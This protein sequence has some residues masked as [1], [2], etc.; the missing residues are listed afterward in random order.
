MKVEIAVTCHFFQ[1]RMSWMISSLIQQQG[2][3]PEIV[4]NA[5]YAIDTGEPSTQETLNY[6]SKRTCGRPITFKHTPY[7]GTSELQYRGLVRNR[8]LAN[9]DADFMFFS[10][11]DML[12]GPYWFSKLLP[13]LKANKDETRMMYTGRYSTDIAKSNVLVDSYRYPAIIPGAFDMVS[14]L[15]KKKRRNCGAGFCQIVSVQSMRDNYGGLYVPPK[16]CRDFSWE[17]KYQKARSDTMFR[18]IVGKRGVDLPYLIHLNHIRDKQVGKHI[19][20]QR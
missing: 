7:L 19:E 13:V 8:Q 10:D 14:Q 6:F 5:A 4:F 20:D 17:K 18:H 12:F 2:D 16:K 15:P 1:K 11:S 9:S 3:I